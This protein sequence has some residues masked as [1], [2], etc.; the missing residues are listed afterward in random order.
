MET[1][2]VLY[3]YYNYIPSVLPQMES[4]KDRMFPDFTPTLGSREVV[5]D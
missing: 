4:R 3:D 1:L 5:S 2:V